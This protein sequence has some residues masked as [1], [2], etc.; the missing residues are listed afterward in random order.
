MTALGSKTLRTQEERD[1]LVEQF[2]PLVRYVVARLPLTM[3]GALDRDDLF[4]VGVM[5]LMH[6]ATTY[7]AARGASF[8]TFAYTAIRGAI[9]DE[10]RKLDPVPRQRRERLRK[11]NRT[12]AELAARLD[13]E[14]TM[15]ELAEALQCSEQEI[16]E[17]LQALHTARTLSL[18]EGRGGGD[19]DEGGGNTLGS[20]LGADDAVDP[21][22]AAAQGERLNQLAK[23]ISEL[24]ETERHVVVLYFHEQLFLKEIG[25]ILGVTESRVSQI[26]TRATERLRLKLRERE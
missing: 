11:L 16:D 22:D 26:L 3:P 19:D 24:P 7:D 6:A 1:R 18:D 17:D 13:R 5:G 23:A 21:G 14:P 8:K 15:L 4:S 20:L 9:L 2:L 10:V 25:Q 12:Q